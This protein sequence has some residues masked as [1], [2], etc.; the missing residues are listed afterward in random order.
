MNYEVIRQVEMKNGDSVPLLNIPMMSDARWNELAEQQ[1]IKNYIR[2]NGK[3][4]ESVKAAFDW[5]R[6]WVR[7]SIEH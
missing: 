3:E 5:Q 2:E 1:A 7:E 4:P 6:Q